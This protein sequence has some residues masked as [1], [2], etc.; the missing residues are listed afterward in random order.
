MESSS[1]KKITNWLF[2]S[3]NHPELSPEDIIKKHWAWNWTIVACA[4][5]FVMTA[6]TFYLKIWPFLWYG[7]TLLAYYAIFIPIFKSAKNFELLSNIFNGLIILTTLI[8][9]LQLGGITSSLGLI[10]VGLNCAMASV[11]GNN[12]R[13]TIAL[14]VLYSIT[15]IIAGIAESFL[16]KPTYISPS[17]NV[18]YFVLNT[19]W[20]NLS[21]FFLIFLYI[22]EY[23]RFEKAEANRLKELDVTRTSLYTNI[24]HEFRT[25]MTVIMG[26]ADQIK[27][28]PDEWLEKG[29]KKIIEQSQ[30]LLNL[31]DQMMDLSKLEAGAM[32]VYLIQGDIIAYLKYLVESF[33][34][35]A[36]SNHIQLHFSSKMHHF[37]MDYDADKLMHIIS[38]LISNALK[39]TPSGGDVTILVRMV[40][41]TEVGNILQISVN[42]SGIGIPSDH[43]SIVFE[44]FYQVGNNT[45]SRGSGSGLGLSITKRLVNLLKGTISV[46]SVPGKGTEFS[47][48]LTVT[49][50]SVI[51]TDHG[52][53]T[54]KPAFVK[55]P[56]ASGNTNVSHLLE[57]SLDEKQPVLL[58]VEDN[59]DV[60]EYLVSLLKNNYN[61]EVAVDGKEGLKNAFTT[62]P[63][64]I[65][66]DVM[67]PK[68]DGF[69]LLEKLKNDIRTSHIPVVLLTARADFDSKI[70]GL[71]KGAD[72][73]LIKPF[74]RVQ[75]FM[76]LNNLM[77]LRKKIQQKLA[78]F[79]VS[80]SS[81]NSISIKPEISFLRKVHGIVEDNL[82]DEDFG[83]QQLCTKIGMSR[84]QLYRKFNALT[85]QSIGKFMRTIR[86]EKAKYL[87]ETQ[88]CNVSEAAYD[89]G[90]KNLSHFSYIFKEEFGFSPSE[91][92]HPT[93]H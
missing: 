58:I 32:S 78:G 23:K 11:L 85:N 74:S 82:Q 24:S 41:K 71:S 93:S 66:S 89:S 88:G 42:D 14:F 47:V 86:L 5:V 34:G 64:I 44:R 65:L 62:V 29:P 79:Q 36:D 91:L 90:F 30:S 48:E 35:I 87:M 54:I 12:I 53:S 10:F 76:T 7:L 70:T 84:A 16:P 77:A 59:K 39:F 51:E 52:I 25:P 38:N 50:N 49:N 3:F 92:T 17:I 4:G 56:T 18:L 15:V 21:A 31:I 61:I 22:K 8:V 63:D 37:Y 73:Y 45:M 20:I 28:N 68:M 81:E 19:L 2:P 6:L 83:I 40:E 72:A 57:S 43:L 26:M 1:Q 27:E 69:A 55:F 46:N 80:S 67:M 60:V 33:Q 13:W 9:M 75:L